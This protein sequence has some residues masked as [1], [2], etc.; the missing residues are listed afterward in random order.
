MYIRHQTRGLQEPGRACHAHGSGLARSRVDHDEFF[1]ESTG[2]EYP[3]EANIKS[4]GYQ[5]VT[6]SPCHKAPAMANSK[7]AP[8]RKKIKRPPARKKSS[9]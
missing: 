9:S 3:N 7:L 6:G 5:K 4:T 1:H 2:A 8:K